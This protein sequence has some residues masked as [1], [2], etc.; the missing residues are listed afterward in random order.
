VRR[1]IRAIRWA[2]ATQAGCT[3]RDRPRL[4]LAGHVDDLG[5]FVWSLVP[6]SVNAALV[7]CSVRL[8]RRERKVALAILVLECAFMAMLVI[9]V[10]AWR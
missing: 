1:E 2:I 9:S 8:S 5:D 6:V 3:W 4:T 7:V 10:I